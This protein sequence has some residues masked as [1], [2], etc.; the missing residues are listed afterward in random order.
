MAATEQL[1]VRLDR[2]EK[3]Q[4][5]SEAK[6]SDSTISDYV[7]RRL[8]DKDLPD[9]DQALIQVL[10]ELKPRVKQ[11]VR[12]IDANLTK[13]HQLRNSATERDGSAAT[14]ARAELSTDELAAVADRLQLQEPAVRPASP[15]RAARR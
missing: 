15:R 5:A 14:R 8:F 7:R 2:R 1:I 13:I 9:A 12:A 10:A 6:R 4:V 3:A 11:A